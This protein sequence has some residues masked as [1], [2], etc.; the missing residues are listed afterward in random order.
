M[1]RPIVLTIAGS[2]SG[3]GAGIQQ[4]LKVFTVLGSYGASVI[5]A[6]TAQN[7]LGVHAIEPVSPSFVRRQLE[8]VLEDLRPTLVKTG[9]LANADIV[10][11][12]AD[13]LS[14]CSDT[15]LVIDPVMVSKGGQ[16]LLDDNGVAAMKEDLFPLATVITPN[17]P[18]AEV[19]TGMHIRNYADMRKAAEVLKAMVP[20]SSILIKGGHLEDSRTS[21]DLLVCHEGVVEF[22]GERFLNKNTHG[23]GCTFSAALTAFMSHGFE[24]EEAVRRSKEFVSLAIKAARPLGSGIGPTDPMAVLEKE[25]ARYQVLKSLEDALKMLEARPARSLVPEVQLNLGYA[26]PWASSIQD[27]AA[28]PGRIV[29][30]GS[31]VGRVRGPAFGASSH[32]ARIIL[33]SMVKDPQCRSAMNIKYDPSYVSKARDLGFVIAEF[34][35]REEPE[36]SRNIEGST[37]VWGV[38]WVIEKYGK[39]PD[40]IYDLGDLGKE[41]MIRVLGP[42]PVVVV[43]KALKVAGLTD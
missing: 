9:M 25:L 4:D 14:R 16:R 39:V 40:F 36:K 42:D 29:G 8:A 17:I 31:G 37:L 43:E 13:L 20:T 1:D 11:E 5:T 15:V 34:S 30:L 12:V 19:L 27:V 2:D 7:T 33:T 24:L 35:R 26:L 10:K 22:P 21:P 3:G 18:E 32:V 41:P 23:T 38:S 6:L 28:F